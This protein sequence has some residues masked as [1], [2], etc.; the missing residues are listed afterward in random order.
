VQVPVLAKGRFAIDSQA[1]LGELLDGNTAITIAC[2]YLDKVVPQFA[3]LV[4]LKQS[5]GR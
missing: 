4:F 3:V 2:H 5:H 1:I